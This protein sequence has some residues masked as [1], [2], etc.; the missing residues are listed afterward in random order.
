MPNR[1]MLKRLSNTFLSLLAA[2]LLTLMA[3]A[4]GGDD[5][6]AH[7]E[8]TH[9]HAEEEAHEHG[10]DTHTHAATAADTAGTYVDSTGAF[11]DDDPQ[12]HHEA[13]AQGEAHAHGEDTHTHD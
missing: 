10:E 8:D 9:T 4:C 7:G 5:D 13:D 1:T 3:T 11:F 6:H 12:D 2:L